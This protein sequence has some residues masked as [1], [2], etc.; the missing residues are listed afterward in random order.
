MIDPRAPDFSNTPAS[1]ARR[2]FVYAPE[3]PTAPPVV[4]IVTPFHQPGRLFHETARSVSRQSLQQWEWVIVNDASP[5]PHS[6]SILHEFRN[7]DPR[8]RVLDHDR[9]RGPSAARN[10]GVRAARADFVF[11]L[12]ADDL[13]EP[14]TLEKSFWCLV[15]QPGYAFANGWSVGF[16]AREYLWSKGFEEGPA[17][18]HGNIVTTT[19]MLRKSRFEAVGGHDETL[20]DGFEDWDFWLRCADRGFWGATIPEFLDWYRRRED[21]GDR[22]STWQHAERIEAFRKTLRERYPRLDRLGF[23]EARPRWHASYEDVPDEL[24]A[25]NRL[26]KSKPRLLLI[27][28]WLTMGG[29][30]KFN[31][32]VT[33]QLVRRGFEISIATTLRGDC[34][35]APEFA[36]FTPDV[37]VLGNFLRLVD[38]PRFLRY[39][40]ESRRPDVVLI[41]NSE[42]GYLLLPYLRARCA[43][44]AYLDF[45]HMEQ[46]DWNNGGYPRHSVAL[47]SCLDR[48]LVSSRHLREWMID[49]GADPQKIEV[50]HINVDSDD[51]RRRPE[52]RR[53]LREAWLVGDEEPVVLYAAR[54]CEQKQPR[55]LCRTLRELVRRGAK[56]RGVIAGD[57]EERAFLE[58][59][60]REHDLGERV[61][62]LGPVS[63][64]RM[65]DLM[66]ASDVFFLPSLWEGIAL[67][68]FE[69]MAMQL[70]VVA[71]DV[72]GQREL[73]TPDCGVL[74]PRAD[75][76]T[77]VERYTDALESLLGDPERRKELGRRARERVSERFRLDQMAERLIEL[78]RAAGAGAARGTPPLVPELAR[79]WA[80]QAV[81]Q[82]RISAVAESLWAERLGRGPGSG[83]H[84]VQL[85]PA[86][87]LH[88]IEA[89][90]SWKLVQRLRRRAVWR[91]LSRV[92]RGGGWGSTPLG[93]E[94]RERLAH[95]KASR[96]YRMIQALKRS[97]PY[98]LYA[99]RRYGPGWEH[100]D[101]SA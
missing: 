33:E 69:A 89:S 57:G 76:D 9:N 65:R 24:P 98:R 13:I 72:G 71:A 14:T 11:F 100:A 101:P 1:E 58:Q 82:L 41:S 45:C 20:R 60:L 48:T 44:P 51:W 17:F 35:W 87:E 73:V 22:W 93:D 30:D 74:L 4:S 86:D 68:L 75:E 84:R 43:G 5:D 56:F 80:T 2:G 10:T 29:A 53:S 55:V 46:E 78:F 97:L 31:L 64:G 6:L 88:R 36:R 12:D 91:A 92:G 8:I 85:A 66:S 81:E 37:F 39:L 54:L 95:I 99:R 16:G 49:R 27:L 96:E 94:P 21:H 77:E 26:E 50:A 90:R 32:D 42:L 28:P 15:S 59:F 83:A 67:S 47:Q 3:D 25:A 52:V 61:L 38:Q 7:R 70:A 23:P 34:S 19:A 40:I 62:F 63:S 79:E 18:L